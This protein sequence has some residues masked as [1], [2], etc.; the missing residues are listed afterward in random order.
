M[1]DLI[2]VMVS[3]ASFLLSFFSEQTF[4]IFLNIGLFVSFIWGGILIYRNITLDS[5]SFISIG[6][7]SNIFFSLGGF[8][9]AIQSSS[10]D[11]VV[12]YL[13]TSGGYVFELT[14]ISWACL[15]TYFFAVFLL[16]INKFLSTS[17]PLH[18]HVFFEQLNLDLSDSQKTKAFVLFALVIEGL[19]LY[20][21]ISGKASFTFIFNSDVKQLAGDSSSIIPLLMLNFSPAGTFLIFILFFYK[22][23]NKILFTLFLIPDLIYLLTI[24][25]RPLI[26]HFLLIIIALF[27]KIRFSD[28][29]RLSQEFGVVERL[30][31][32]RR[33]HFFAVLTIVLACLAAV[34]FLS[35]FRFFIIAQD[36][37]FTGTSPIDLFQDFIFSGKIFSSFSS[38]DISEQV[39]DNFS[40]RNSLSLGYLTHTIAGFAKAKQF[41]YG[42]I[43]FSSIL[44]AI[45]SNLGLYDKLELSNYGQTLIADVIKNGHGDAAKSIATYSFAD[46]FL[47]GPLIYGL[48]LYIFSYYF[49]RF[50]KANSSANSLTYCVCFACMTNFYLQMPETEMTVFFLLIRDS[51]IVIFIYN[52]VI[53][54]KRR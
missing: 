13:R 39:Q 28:D 14:D 36:Q 44:Y 27:V 7:G 47:L 46:F 31:Q 42:A 24:G 53:S 41:I 38:S 8:W 45:P 22:K 1:I 49:F 21:L 51:L 20:L 15:Y 26:Y 4:S 40:I 12:D 50:I 43:L 33:K 9:Y 10:L 29:N 3:I 35:I 30:R 32:Y 16:F 18:H 34:Q 25:R 5:F 37:S 19:K 11:R 52:L 54:L 17:S 48:V 2:L 6:V 23:I